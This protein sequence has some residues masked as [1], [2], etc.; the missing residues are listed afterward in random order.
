MLKPTLVLG[1]SLK[2]NRYSHFA[3]QKLTKYKHEVYPVGLRA[4]EI[5]GVAVV[6]FESAIAQ[7]QQHKAYFDTVTLY[8][9]PKHQESYME[10]IISL[11][12]KRVIFN[13]GTENPIFYKLL[14]ENS[15]PYEIA[16]TLVLLSTNQY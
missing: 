10:Y 13:P 16:C 7:A 14:E 11:A 5:D 3:V 4:G 6:T 9:G 15:I 2:S 12:P 8:L 1:A